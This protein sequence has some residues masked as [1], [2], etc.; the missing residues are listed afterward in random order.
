VCVYVYVNIVCLAGQLLPVEVSVSVYVYVNIV[1]PAGQLLPIEVGVR[2]RERALI[3]Y[4]LFTLS[5]SHY[6][7]LH[8]TTLHHTTPLHYYPTDAT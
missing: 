3:H 7:T 1:C 4:L 6:T 5:T 8:H 2:E